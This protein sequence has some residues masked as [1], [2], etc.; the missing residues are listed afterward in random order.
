VFSSGSAK[1]FMMLSMSSSSYFIFFFSL[2]NHKLSLNN[3]LSALEISL[4][5]IVLHLIHPL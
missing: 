2:S 1:V 3:Q 4:W 5:L